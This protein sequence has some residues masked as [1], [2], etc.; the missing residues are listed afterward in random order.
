MESKSLYK[1]ESCGTYGTFQ[2][3]IIVGATKL[4]NTQAERIRIATRE[5]VDRIE[6]AVMGEIIKND[7]DVMARGKE[8]KE[9]LLGLFPGTPFVEEIPNGYCPRWCCRHLP[10]FVVT[11]QVGRIKIG[12]RKRVIL[13]D[14]SQTL[15]TKNSHELFEA[16]QVTMDEHMIHAWGYEDAKR[17]IDAILTSTKPA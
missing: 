17:Y 6:D 13:I 4:P 2:I 10:W 11:T 14:W 9:R 15:Q 8:Q 1:A 12:W 7:P 5:A 3:E 16:E